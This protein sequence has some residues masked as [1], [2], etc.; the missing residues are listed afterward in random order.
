MSYRVPG[1]ENLFFIVKV[2][3]LIKM[4]QQDNPRQLRFVIVDRESRFIHS[5]MRSTRPDSSLKETAVRIGSNPSGGLLTDLSETGAGDWRRFTRDWPTWYFASPV[6]EAAGALT[7]TRETAAL[8]AARQSAYRSAFLLLVV[9]RQGIACVLKI[10][11][12]ITKPLVQLAE[13]VA[14]L[15]ERHWKLRFQHKSRDDLSVARSISAMAKRLE[16]RDEALRDLRASNISHIAERLRGSYFYYMLDDQGLITY[17]SPSVRLHL[18]SVSDTITRQT[19]Y[20]LVDEE[21][22]GTVGKTMRGYQGRT[23]WCSPE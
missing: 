1:L 19:S 4:L 20:R 12:F 23:P 18:V 9:P 13:A 14:F 8:S 7:H 11:G 10:S 22:A 6:P 2:S 15:G 16:E 3:G 17:I 5:D 21:G